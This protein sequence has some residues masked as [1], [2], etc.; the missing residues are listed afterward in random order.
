MLSKNSVS[1][2]QETHYK[3]Q[4]VNSAWENFLFILSITKNKL[5]EQNVELFN[6]YLPLHFEELKNQDTM[7]WTLL[8]SM[9]SAS[10]PSLFAIVEP[11]RK[12]K[13]FF[14]SRELPPYPLPYETISLFSGL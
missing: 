9:C 7:Y 4:M 14:P 3:H 8:T 11:I 1:T 6:T 12:A 2:S 13:H 10:Q 5:C